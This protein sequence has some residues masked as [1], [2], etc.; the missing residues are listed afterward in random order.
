M[1]SFI[2]RNKVRKINRAVKIR[3]YPNAEQ[4]VQIEKTI[5]CSRFIYNYMLADKMEH[6]KKEKKMLR[7]TPASYKKEYPWLKEVDSLALAN[8]QMHLESAFHKFF[9]EPSAGFPR[10]KSKKSSR[11]SYTTNV[12]NGNIFLEGK[13]LKL[14]KMT[15]VRMKL[16]RP[17]SEKW[18]LKSVTVSREPSGKYFAS[19]L[20]CCENQT[21]EKRPAEKFIGIDFAMQGIYIEKTVMFMCDRTCDLFKVGNFNIK[22]CLLFLVCI[23]LLVACGENDPI[24]SRNRHPRQQEESHSEQSG[25]VPAVAKED[26]A[27]Y[28]RFDMSRDINVAL[29]LVEAQKE[30]LQ[31]NGKMIKITEAV[32]KRKDYQKGSFVLYVTGTVNGSPFKNEFT[33]TGFVSKP[34]DYQMVNGAQ[35]E[36]K[37]NADYYAKLDFDSFYRLHKV[38]MFTIENLGRLVDFYSINVG[39]EKYLF[40]LEDLE[41]TVL[42]DIKYEQNQLSFYLR[43]NNSRSKKRISLLF[44]KNKY[45]EGKVTVNT[46][47]IKQKY[48]RGI[49]ENPSL[50]NGHIFSY[51]ESAYA[52]EISTTLKEKSDTGNML[53]LHLSMYAKGNGGLLL[54]E[55]DK[56]FTGFK[57]LSELKNELI[58]YSTPDLHEF[59]KNKLKN[60]NYGDVKNKFSNSIDRWIQYVEFVIKDHDSLQWEK[61]KW[62][63]N[64]LNG[65]FSSV[66]DI[67]LD[68]VRFELNSAQLKEIGGKRFLYIV[69]QMIG[70]NDLVLTSDAILFNMSIHIPSSL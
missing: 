15:A 20:F 63:K 48:M 59:V 66:K 29:G 60:S 26:V 54:A 9:R 16:H 35:A 68:N 2:C 47:F 67:Y 37:A 21:A 34:D 64:V 52:V 12:V 38:N 62:S 4:R 17:I 50:F 23:M 41:K 31:I 10:F 19:L 55:F 14:P 65:L 1:K 32:V 61:N 6:Y 46:D 43:Y 57:P 30:T 18:K 49:Y 7:N 3:I 5:G 40:T 58:A 8:V 24:E 42:E 45:Y 53:T 56:I 25:S 39:G 69:F 70:A 51:D 44:D 33:F 36:W 27:A 28:F 22:R 11:K 13:Y